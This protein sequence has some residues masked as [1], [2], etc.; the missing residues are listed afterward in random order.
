MPA[1]L[2]LPCSL[3]LLERVTPAAFG[4]VFTGE[5]TLPGTR[6]SKLPAHVRFVEEYGAAAHRLLAEHRDK[7]D[8]SPLPLAL[9]L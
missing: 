7:V 4:D 9:Q 6:E 2:R 8:G 5:L 1:A 3:R